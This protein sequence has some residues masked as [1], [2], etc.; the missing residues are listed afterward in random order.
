MKANKSRF[1]HFWGKIRSLLEEEKYLGPY[2][3]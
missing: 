2:F 3:I 1:Q